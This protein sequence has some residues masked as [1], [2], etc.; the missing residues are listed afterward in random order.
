MLGKVYAGTAGGIQKVP[1]G[2]A[3]LEDLRG[4]CI[5]RE[6]VF[7][8]LSMKDPASDQFTVH[9]S[10]LS[11]SPELHLLPLFKGAASQQVC[12]L[13]FALTARGG[14]PHRVALPHLVAQAEFID[15]MDPGQSI[16]IVI[17]L[18]CF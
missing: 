8:F 10:A 17:P 13:F 18:H 16:A 9:C 4:C 7:F 6:N 14:A 15:T 5:S 11:L 12:S 2:K 1:N 3:R